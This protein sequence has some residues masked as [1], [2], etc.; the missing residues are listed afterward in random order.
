M[1]KRSPR[2]SSYVIIYN[3]KDNA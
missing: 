1:L 3:G 2:N